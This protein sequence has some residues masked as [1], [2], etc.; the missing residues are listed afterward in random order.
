MKINLATWDRILRY[1]LGM[2]LSTW[3]VAGGPWWCYAGLYLLVT[4]SWGLCPIY[5]LLKIR[6]YHDKFQL[7]RRETL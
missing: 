1:L 4:A 6:T 2:I 5:G 7:K 3:A